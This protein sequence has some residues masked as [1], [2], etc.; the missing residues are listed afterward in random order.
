LQW[1]IFPLTHR[2]ETGP[3]SVAFL[4]PFLDQL[5]SRIFSYVFLEDF[6]SRLVGKAGDALFSLTMA[7]QDMFSHLVQQLIQ[8]HIASAD[9]QHRLSKAFTSLT[10]TMI[11][12]ASLAHDGI[13]S[14][15]LEIGFGEFLGT[16]SLPHFREYQKEFPLFV[17][18]AR[19]ILRVK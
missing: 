11:R 4:A 2:F 15:Q 8:Q 3:E 1:L 17:V 18:Q 5:M 9:T 6:E 13:V 14:G 12:V 7:R 10:Q 16:A 19:G